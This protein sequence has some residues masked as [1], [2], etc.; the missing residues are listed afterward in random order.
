MKYTIRTLF[1][2]LLAST[3]GGLT[4]ASAETLEIPI[5][6]MTCPFCADGLHRK[7]GGLPGVEKVEISLKLKKARLLLKDGASID[8]GVIRK[9]IIDSGFTPGDV[10]VK[11]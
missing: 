9:T 10:V 6:G 7:L 3:L 1:V 5:R 8:D 4:M 11:P 2:I